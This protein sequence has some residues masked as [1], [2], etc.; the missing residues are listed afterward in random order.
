MSKPS[1]VNLTASLEYP[2]ATAY[3][4]EMLLGQ[5]VVENL[6]AD[7]TIYAITQR[8]AIYFDNVNIKELARGRFICQITDGKNIPI[9]C[10]FNIPVEEWDVLNVE[11]KFY[12][13]KEK[14]DASNDFFNKIEA[15]QIHLRNKPPMWISA[16]VFIY[17]HYNSPLHYKISGNITPYLIHKLHYIGQTTKQN[18]T[19]RLAHHR[20]LTRVITLEE[21]VNNNNIGTPHEITIMTFKINSDD[22]AISG[23]HI[24]NEI[25]AAL[26]NK[27]QP[28]YN[29]VKYNNYPNIENG[30]KKIN[31]A[32]WQFE[33]KNLPIS[34]YTE[35]Y[36]MKNSIIEWE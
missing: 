19:K 23:I 18:I 5:E 29:E 2:I 30:F 36:S 16:N 11:S 10:F 35:K 27:F 22:E 32:L 24:T 4:L 21:P 20:K 6:V 34:L 13:K 7:C 17:L 25:E 31:K 9:D 1:Q 33:I 3:D 14:K 8:P 15:I 26:I 28:F 12:S